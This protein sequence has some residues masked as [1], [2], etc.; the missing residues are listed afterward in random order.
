MFIIYFL[1]SDKNIAK[2]FADKGIVKPI[3]LAWIS[4][5][6]RDTNAS[7]NEMIWDKYLKRHPT[8]ICN[9]VTKVLFQRKETEKLHRFL[10]WKNLNK[11]LIAKS[12]LGK[13]YSI[14]FDSLFYKDDYDI[15]IEELE[16]AI[17]FLSLKDFKPNTLKR[18]KLGPDVLSQRFW[19]VI[20]N[21]AKKK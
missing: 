16:K 20:N 5:F 17:V 11:S 10:N 12:E 14:L 9:Q 13:A 2:K 21:S 7:D 3:C 1:F 19:S 15:I 8:I 4:N 18:I 6:I